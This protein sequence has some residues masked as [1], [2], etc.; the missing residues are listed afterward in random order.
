MELRALCSAKDPP[1]AW[2]L[3]CRLREELIA[4]VRDLGNGR[5]LPKHRLAWQP[6]SDRQAG[7]QQGTLSG[8]LDTER[9]C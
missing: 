9:M 6:E 5:F 2:R 3:H 7:A 8:K 4:F 1:T